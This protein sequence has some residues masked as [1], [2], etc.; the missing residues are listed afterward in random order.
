MRCDKYRGRG[1]ESFGLYI[2]TFKLYI[3]HL[4]IQ[5]F[6]QRN[7]LYTYTEEGMCTHIV[8]MVAEECSVILVCVNDSPR[9]TGED[10]KNWLWFSVQWCKLGHDPEIHTVA[11]TCI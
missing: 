8:S 4:N 11:Q 5:Q 9:H 7:I 6:S 10:V 1:S 2:A 3:L